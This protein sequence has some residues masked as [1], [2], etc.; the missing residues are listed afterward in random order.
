ML[1]FESAMVCWHVMHVIRGLW[2]KNRDA[3]QR[4]SRKKYKKIKI[5]FNKT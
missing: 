1:D 2:I 3:E 4:R 5:E